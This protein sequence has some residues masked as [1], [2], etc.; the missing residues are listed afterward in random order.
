MNLVGGDPFIA[1]IIV[2]VIVV[3]SIA[4]WYGIRLLYLRS[5]N[6]KIAANPSA[7]VAVFHTR[8]LTAY[9]VLVYD[10][11]GAIEVTNEQRRYLP[12]ELSKLKKVTRYIPAP[13]GHGTAVY[14]PFAEA[15]FDKPWPAGQPEFCQFKMRHINYLE[16]IPVPMIWS[17]PEK[18]MDNPE[19]L[20][21]ISAD[22]AQIVAD[23]SQIEATRISEREL[24]KDWMSIAVAV[25][26]VPLIFLLCIGTLAGVAILAF[27]IFQ[28]MQRIAMM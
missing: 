15:S 17:N 8:H 10:V 27:M 4:G 2:L 28:I 7:M 22:A 6:A 14:F 24:F 12:G 26:R 19:L 25:K 11:D 1:I 3:V 18:Y 13:K 16:G 5:K 9:D 20:K 21:Q 23:K